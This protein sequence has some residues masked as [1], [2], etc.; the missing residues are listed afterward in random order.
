MDFRHATFGIGTIFAGHVQIGTFKENGE[1]S[2]WDV[3]DP[4]KAI[5]ITLKHDIYSKLVIEVEHPEEVI[6]Q[7]Q[8][9]IRKI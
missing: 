9:K 4:E 1:K 8:S 5:L 7:I 6:R 2:F 3:Y